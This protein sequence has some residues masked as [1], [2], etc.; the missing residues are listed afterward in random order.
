[1]ENDLTKPKDEV[2]KTSE[3]EV[4]TISEIFDPH[5]VQHIST[6]FSPTPILSVVDDSLPYHQL[7]G[8]GL[9][10]LCY[11]LIS[12]RGGVPR[13]FGNSGQKQYA[14]DLIV[15]DGNDC[16]VYQCK[17]VNSFTWQNMA[18]ALK[19]F[20]KQWLG[21]DQL[22]RPTKF[23][24]C[25]PLPLR[26]RTINEEWTILEREFFGSTGVRIEAWD[27]EYFD[28]QLKKHPD[29]VSDLFSAQAAERF[30]DLADWNE[31]L[32]RPVRPGSGEPTGNRYL[33]KKAA[34]QIYIDARLIEDFTQK[35]ERHNSLLI[36]GLPG[37]GK[38][39]TGLALAELFRR[40]LYRVF[41]INMRRDLSEDALV[42]GIRGRL[43]RP[44][45]F[46]ID[47]CHG[48]YDMLEGVQDRLQ[49]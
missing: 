21:H 11:S 49:E 18:K 25:C 16:T 3:E 7:G 15:T 28:S 14:I 33:E 34:G 32:F 10:R 36:L 27:Q 6:S 1:M 22:P 42:R 40:S 20:E 45:I 43:A 2:G 41:Y 48:K 31:D 29:I 30:C 8:P 24:L 26:E 23:V 17:N 37:S 19:L 46:L 44:T 39:T 12:A 5:L 38:T 35:L 4:V 9:E 13:Y 47:D